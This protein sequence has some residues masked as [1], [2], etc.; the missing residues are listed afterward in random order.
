M[1]EKW[2]DHVSLMAS[3]SAYDRQGTGIGA[4]DWCNSSSGYY[5][6]VHCFYLAVP[7]LWTVQANPSIQP[8]AM[9]KFNQ[10]GMRCG[11]SQN[12]A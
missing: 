9:Q 8:G 7:G 6:C 1:E 10:P 2:A 11:G 4:V 5:S 3:P 12:M